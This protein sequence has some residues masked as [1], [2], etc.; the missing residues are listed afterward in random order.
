MKGEGKESG[1]ERIGEEGVT[2]EGEEEEGGGG[3]QV[4]G[5]RRT[6][7]GRE[8]ERNLALMVIS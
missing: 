4:G 8:G 3:R 7:R 6:G 5:V 2:G 1:G